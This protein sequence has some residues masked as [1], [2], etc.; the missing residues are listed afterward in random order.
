MGNKNVP[1]RLKRKAFN[2]CILPAMIYGCET[3]SLSN[4]QVELLVTTQR[5]MEI[6][7][8]GVTLTD[9]RSTEW[10]RKQS[11]VTDII[12]S[13]RESKHRWAGH[14]VR[15]R[16][17]RWTITVTEWIPRGNKRPRSRP[18]TRWCDD[19]MQYVGTYVESHCER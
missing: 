1:K 12:R 18:R 16:D 9:R 19:L 3:W 8:M 6:I 13:I 4:I 7:M 14:V 17:N 11:G 5:K 15:R 10:I 2:E